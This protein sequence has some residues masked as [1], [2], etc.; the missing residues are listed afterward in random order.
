MNLG[1][2]LF[3]EARAHGAAAGLAAAN[4][5]Y[6]SARRRGV[7]ASDYCCLELGTKGGFA[8]GHAQ[9]S[10]YRCEEG[11]GSNTLF[12]LAPL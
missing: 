9:S 8:A 5:G 1:L 6:V 10:G 7:S 4:R 11:F 2:L 12:V 3:P